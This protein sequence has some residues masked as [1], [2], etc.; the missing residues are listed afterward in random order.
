MTY[1]AFFVSFSYNGA[2]SS[3]EK[4]LCWTDLHEFDVSYEHQ[5][6]G[7]IIITLLFFIDQNNISH[8]YNIYITMTKTQKLD[9]DQICWYWSDDQINTRT[10]SYE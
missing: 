8:S 4:G 1:F 9:I 3:I 5:L 2:K 7:L 6:F 10:M